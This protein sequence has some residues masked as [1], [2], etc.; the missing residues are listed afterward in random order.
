VASSQR[1]SA[2]ERLRTTPAELRAAAIAAVALIVSMVLP[3][4]QKSYFAQVNGHNEAVQDNL[5]ALQAFSFVEGAILL[6]AVGV[7][8]LVWARANRRGFHLPGGDGAVITA[9]GCWALLLLI[10]RLFDK[11]NVQGAA[12]MGVQWGI[13]GAMLAAGALIA[14]G[15]RVRA[16]HRPE[17]PN[18]AADDFDFAT[19]PRRRSS[20]EGRR[21]RDPGAVTDV[22]RDRPSWEGDPPVPPS[23]AE[24][25]PRDGEPPPP[26]PRTARRT[27][28]RNGSNEPP[29][30]DRLF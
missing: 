11:P 28:R 7:L 23:R 18:P 21:P 15:G 6:V 2:I 25:P 22:L 10:W 4:Y 27:R 14:A 30:H 17:P 8:F 26:P 9:A 16:A 1:T 24:A 20:H 19:P 12:T 5:S 29:A 13:F 3:W